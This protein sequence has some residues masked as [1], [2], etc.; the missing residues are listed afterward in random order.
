M[1]ELSICQ[2]L[3]EQVARVARD[4]RAKAV[5]RIRV[6]NG[7]LSG[8]DS[9]FL[10]HAFAVARFGT[11]AE[12]AELS[13]EPEPLRVRCKICGQESPAT[14]NV[15]VCSNCGDWRTEVLSGDTLLLASVELEID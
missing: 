13:M 2:A 9:Y 5:H 11:L 6:R 4:N 12:N 10:E 14:V 7:P 1:H 8:V 3:L 15:L